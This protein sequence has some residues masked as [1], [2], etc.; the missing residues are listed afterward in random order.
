MRYVIIGSSAA[1]IAAAGA[2]RRSRQAEEVFVISAERHPPY[3]RPLIPYLIE[4]TKTPEEIQR[5]ATRLPPGVDMRLGRRVVRLDPTAHTVLLDDGE[6]LGYDRLLLATGSVASRP[7]IP[8]LDGP[9]VHTLHDWDDALAIAQVAQGA[10]RAVIL[11]AGRIGMKCAFAL[12]HLGLDVTVV[13]IENRI[14]PQQ[15]DETGAAI[16]TRVVQAAGI[17]LLLH[18]T[19]A[20]VEHPEG[21]PKRII[22]QDGRELTADLVIAAT[23][24]RANAALAR[25][26]GLRVDHGVLVDEGMRTSAPDV[27]A[28]G[29]VVQTTDVVTGEPMV[30]GIWTN[31]AAMGQVAGENMA[32]GNRRFVGAFR[33]LNAMELGGLP[34]ISVGRIDPP[35]GDGY[36]VFA[37]Q[38]DQTY[39][40]LVFRDDVLVGLILIGRV[41][42]AGV[43]QT[44]IREQ[45]PLGATLRERLLEPTFSYAHFVVPQPVQVDR[46]LP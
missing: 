19:F 12:R 36:K 23:G 9:G 31:A 18:T 17:H 8:G 28:A 40:K 1:G 42:G 3:H 33:L 30:S 37:R 24:V 5:E 43:Y 7:P 32:G 44:L 26:A 21:A 41:E 13:E 2:I 38:R 16:F 46:Y 11:G 15:L 34:V 27:Y 45:V 39:R 35:D 25:D 10:E 4:G 6:S 22:L 20:R 29:D 14:V